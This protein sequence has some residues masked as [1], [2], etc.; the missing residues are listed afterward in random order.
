M[1]TA[2]LQRGLDQV[3]AT[4]RQRLCLGSLAVGV[5]VGTSLVMARATPFNDT[6]VVFLVAALAM[7]VAVEPDEHLATIVMVVVVLHWL[8]LG[9]EVT[10]P[11]AMP[12]AVALLTFHTVVALLAVT[13]HTSVVERTVLLRWLT[14][15]LAAGA[16]TVATWLAVVV[17]ERRSLPG[18][19]ALSVAAFASV[20][21]AVVAFRL[22][23]SAPEEGEA[24]AS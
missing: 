24:D 13:P 14:R 10:S 2:R 15:S 1:R 9:E 16:A 17:F 23:T 21:A 12:V 20:T 5:I 3:L 22:V 6:W 4:T 19:T 11:W 8:A 18:N 7:V